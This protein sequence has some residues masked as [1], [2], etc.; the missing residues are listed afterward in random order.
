MLF[1]DNPETIT[2]LIA[3]FPKLLSDAVLMASSICCLKTDSVPSSLM[4]LLL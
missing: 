3:S 2:N 1:K 4:S